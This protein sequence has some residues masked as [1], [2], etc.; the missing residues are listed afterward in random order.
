MKINEKT[1]DQ[2]TKQ[3]LIKVIIRL[4]KLNNGEYLVQHELTNIIRENER[5]KL[6]PLEI[7]TKDA[8]KELKDFE[9]QMCEKYGCKTIGECLCKL[10]LDEKYKYLIHVN[11]HIDC[12]DNEMKEMDRQ[13]TKRKAFY[14]NERGRN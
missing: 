5:A 1:L 3:D 12:L 9:K 13:D 6:S 10:N 7:A 11:K 14:E 8:E 4:S 2:F